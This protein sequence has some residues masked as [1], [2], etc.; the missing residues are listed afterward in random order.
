MF[1]PALSIAQEIVCLVNYCFGIS[2]WGTNN[3]NSR[4]A[5]VMGIVFFYKFPVMKYAT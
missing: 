2:R 1:L 5:E 3:F 4:V